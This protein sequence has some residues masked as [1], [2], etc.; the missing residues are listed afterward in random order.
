MFL[1]TVAFVH[2]SAPPYCTVSVDSILGRDDSVSVQGP[3]K[4]LRAARDAVRS[5]PR[6]LPDGGAIVCLHTG[7]FSEPLVLDDP[8]LDSGDDEQR[9]I[10]WLGGVPRSPQAEAEAE[11]AAAAQQPQAQAQQQGPAM[12]QAPGVWPRT[13]L[14]YGVRVTFTPPAPGAGA[15]WTASLPSFGV[16]DYGQWTP[17]GFLIP[18]GGCSTAPLELFA[19]AD[20]G[21]GDATPMTVARW[22]NVADADASA[23]PYSKW[24]DEGSWTRAQYVKG[25]D[26]LN[27]SLYAASDVPFAN[28]TASIATGQVYYSGYPFYDWA[29]ANMPVVGYNASSRLLEVEAGL[30]PYTFAFSGKYFLQNAAE[31]LDAPG[32]YYLNTSTGLLSFIPPAG[33]GAAVA[34]WVTNATNASDATGALVALEAVKHVSL[35]NVTLSYSRQSGV[36]VAN[37]YDVQV[38]NVTITAMGASGISVVDSNSTLIAGANVSHTG[39]TAIDFWGGGD[40][41]SLTSSGNVAVDSSVRHFGRLCLSYQ[42]GITMGS[43]GGVIAHC[44]IGGGPHLGTN[45]QSNDGLLEY[46]KVHDTVLAACDMGAFY[47]GAQDWSVWNATVRYSFFYRNGYATTGCSDVSGNDVAA[48]Y[49][50]E[51]Q[52]GYAAYSNV[53]YAPMAGWNFSYLSHPRETY[54]HLYNGGVSTQSWNSLVIDANISYFQSEWSLTEDGYANNC[55]VNS[56]RLQGMR[57]MRWNTGVYA[58]H[59]PSLA[60]LQ[61]GCD[62]DLPACAAD[63]TCPGAPYNSG[64]STAVNVNVTGQVLKYGV[65][66]SVFDPSRFNTTGQWDGADPGFE[67]GSPAAARATLNFQLLDTSPAY[68]MGFTKIPMQCFGP[69]ACEEEQRPYPRAKDAARALAAQQQRLV[70]DNSTS[71]SVTSC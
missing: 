17:H 39:G 9:R 59:Y 44:D 7:F 25:Q 33:A 36:L 34:G 4:T 45:V 56:S 48:I 40:R 43:I 61:D 31:A 42:G 3:W 26:Y 14:S 16:R 41:P 19:D 71:T 54:A 23:A 51:A 6:P 20:D 10:T 60:A 30:S 12:Q 50:D 49:F 21:D 57:A 11:A 65:N 1:L 29:D 64:Y 32:E 68:A 24:T 70:I 55:A 46:S 27:S 58:A 62:A 67:A 15:A 37:C 5:L 28:W 18:H 66:A 52:S 38:V 8:V 22:P 63:P 53:I 69:Y 35:V 2:A 13:E 47:T